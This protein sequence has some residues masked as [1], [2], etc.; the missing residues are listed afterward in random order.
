MNFIEEKNF[1]LLERSEDRGQVAL[2]LEQRA[3]TGFNHDAQFAGDDLRER[4]LA[5]ARRAIQQHVVERFAAAARR[6]DG[7]LDVL[8]HTRLADVVGK[9]LRANARVNSRILIKRRAGDD[10]LRRSLHPRLASRT[11]THAITSQIPTAI[12]F[13]RARRGAR[14]QMPRK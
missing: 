8:L 10:A 6:L 11:R 13:Q 12:I 5:Q 3:G 7:D 2:A 1:A 4:R 14:P 9:A